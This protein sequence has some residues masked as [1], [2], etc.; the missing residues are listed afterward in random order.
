MD[1]DTSDATERPAGE[2]ARLSERELEVSQLLAL[3]KTNK[4]IGTVLGISPRTVQIHVTH[5][6][7]K[8]GVHSRACAAIWLVEHAM[9]R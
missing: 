4:E 3:G 5:I 7:D 6:F 9:R 8:L 2:L 1:S